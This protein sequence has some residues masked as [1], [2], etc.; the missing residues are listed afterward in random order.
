M[1]HLSENLYMKPKFDEL[2]KSLK[3]Q[4]FDDR[5]MAMNALIAM[6]EGIVEELISILS[7]PRVVDDRSDYVRGHTAEI[8][9]QLGKGN[10]KTFDILIEA[11]ESENEIL[12]EKAIGALGKLGDR[13]AIGLLVAQLRNHWD[14][15]TR[16]E[17]AWALAK[18]PEQ[19][20]IR[21]LIR[22]FSDEHEIVRN[23]SVYALSQI[24]EVAREQ[25]VDALKN[26]C[27]LIRQ[28][29]SETLDEIKKAK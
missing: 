24:G 19:W 17:S 2:I 6:G 1:N 3:S 28:H 18:Y 21:V 9:G 7:Q 13:R 5:L 23:A 27:P 15:D 16:E 10:P 22:A 26:E 12:R 20:V 25:L 8:L 11:T 14:A 29:A 4:S